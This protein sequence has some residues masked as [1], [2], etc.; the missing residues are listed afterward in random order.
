MNISM[1]IFAAMKKEFTSRGKKHEELEM[2]EQFYVDS[3][4]FRSL[5]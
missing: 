5:Q 4:T 2:D 3:G 1:F